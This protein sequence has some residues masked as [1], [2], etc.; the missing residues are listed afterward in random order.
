MRISPA[1]AEDEVDVTALWHRTALTR[2]WNDAQADFQR[3]REC[4]QATVLVAREQGTILGSVMVGDDGH[5]GW[6]YYLAVD[7]D[8]RR[9]GLG[10]AL[11]RSAEDWLRGR[12]Q[13]RV[14]LMVRDDNNA[15]S[16]FYGALGYGNQECQV[17][18]RAL[19]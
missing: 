12:G 16:G 19:A 13:S 9:N 7:E 3:A 1:T 6:L 11:V 5:R 2:P 8:H 18:G 10:A 17:L 14:R 4:E 15:V